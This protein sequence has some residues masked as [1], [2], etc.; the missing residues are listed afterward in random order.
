MLLNVRPVCDIT[1]G[2]VTFWEHVT[3][4]IVVARCVAVTSQVW[5]CG[6]YVGKQTYMGCSPPFPLC[7]VGMQRVHRSMYLSILWKVFFLGGGVPR[8]QNLFQNLS[9]YIIDTLKDIE[10]RV[11]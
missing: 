6:Y 8:L 1:I 9:V 7:I 5:L 3:P 2:I 4:T 11:E 10:D